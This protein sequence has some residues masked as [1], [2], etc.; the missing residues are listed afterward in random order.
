MGEII[1]GIASGALFGVL[2]GY[3]GMKIYLK[4]NDN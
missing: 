3:V 4:L 2:V 1:M